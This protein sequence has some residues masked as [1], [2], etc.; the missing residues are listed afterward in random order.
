MKRLLLWMLLFLPVLATAKEDTFRRWEIALS[1][2]VNN[3]YAWE[4]EPSFTFFLCKY[5]GITA[6]V[7]FT[8]Q[9]YDEYYSGPAPGGKEMVWTIN[10]DE[11]NAKRILFRPAIRLR[12]PN[13]NGRGDRD[14]KVTFNVE[15]GVY[16][17][18]PVNETLQVGYRN[19]NHFVPGG[20][21]ES[22]TNKDGDWLYW[23]AKSFMQVEIENWVF[24]AGYTI[25]NYDVYGGRRN[26][27][28]ERKPLNDILWKKKMTHSFFLSVGIQF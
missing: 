21:T 11:S 18:V 26:M 24:S 5:A 17:A 7:N 12:T 13:L 27:V 23:N 6:G 20:L 4:V 3:N 16:M 28:I 14:F 8:G 1:G 2:G 15:P 19:G 9:F 22:V 25:S 10:S